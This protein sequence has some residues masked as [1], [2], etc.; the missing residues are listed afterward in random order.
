MTE[1]TKMQD[2]TDFKTDLAKRKF[3]R[4]TLT[5]EAE[6]YLKK[7][8][9]GGGNLAS[10]LVGF[11]KEALGIVLFTNVADDVLLD[12][13]MEI[14]INHEDYGLIKAKVRNIF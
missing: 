11:A 3:V 1:E 7:D 9:R 12:V 5:K 13:L 14:Y 10:Y 8:N 2:L 4:K 6:R